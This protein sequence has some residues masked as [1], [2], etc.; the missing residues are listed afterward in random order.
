MLRFV[1]FDSVAL[2]NWVPL[3]S[4]LPPITNYDSNFFVPGK[5]KEFYLSRKCLHRLN[6]LDI[7]IYLIIFY[8]FNLNVS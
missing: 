3:D 4:R 7:A 1:V 8:Y 5:N 6:S 2:P